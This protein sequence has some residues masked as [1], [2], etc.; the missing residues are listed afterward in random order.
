VPLSQTSAHTEGPVDRRVGE[1]IWKQPEVRIAMGRE[2]RCTAQVGVEMVEVT[3]LLES[4]TIILRGALKR[5]WEIAALRGLRHTGD[6]LCFDVG[7]ESVALLLGEKEAASWLKKLQTPPPT[8][9]AKLGVSANNPA[10]LLGPSAGPL[11]PALVEALTGCLSADAEAAHVLV[12]V[13]TSPTELPAVAEFHSGMSCDALW[14]VHPKG[15]G[16]SPS[17]AEVRTALRE[18]GYT[19]NKT[20]A[21]SGRLTATRYLRRRH[22]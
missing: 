6:A 16:A 19:D 4:T 14:A 15:P 18:W 13:L 3:A 17:A 12:A 20:C 2:A 21:V 8:L 5:H 7:A 11:D 9:A 1:K 22:G 10:F